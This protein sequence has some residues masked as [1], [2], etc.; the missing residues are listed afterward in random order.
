MTSRAHREMIKCHRQQFA[1][2]IGLIFP[3]SFCQNTKQVP[4]P[5][6]L[7]Q[8]LPAGPAGGTGLKG[9]RRVFRRARYRYRRKFSFSL[10]YR[11]TKRRTFRALGHGVRSAFHIASGIDTAVLCQQRRPHQKAGLRCISVFPDLHRSPDQ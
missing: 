11:G 6:K 7:P 3:F 8:H 1:E 10:G 4:I 2:P 9:R 5:A